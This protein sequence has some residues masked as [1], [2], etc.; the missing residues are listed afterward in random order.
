M[1]G[2]QCAA[3]VFVPNLF[4]Y[5]LLLRIQNYRHQGRVPSTADQRHSVQRVIVQVMQRY[6]CY[7]DKAECN[8]QLCACNLGLQ[9]VGCAAGLARLLP[10]DLGGCGVM[11]GCS[12]G[13]R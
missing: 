1:D 5:M 3:W 10:T 8:S 11:H 13:C 7:R 2:M 12:G 9:R 6:A 4:E